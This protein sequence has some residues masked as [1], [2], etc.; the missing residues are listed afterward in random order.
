MRQRRATLIA[1]LVLCSAFFTGAWSAAAPTATT[2]HGPA[3]SGTW[4]TARVVPGTKALNQ[5]GRATIASISCVSPGNCSAG[6]TYA[7]AMGTLKPVTQALVVTETGGR[8]GTA[9]E[10]PGTAALNT[11]GTARVVSISC[12]AAGDCAA[13][14]FYTDASGNAQ[15]FVVTETG[16]T[17]G[18]A[19]EV[20]G[21][22]GLDRG[23]PGAEVNSVSCAAVG[24]CAAGGFYTETSGH[25]QAFVVT[26]SSGHWGTAREVPGSATLNAG[27]FAGITSLS[28]DTVGNCSAGGYYAT[29]TVDFIPTLEAMVVTETGGTWRAAREVPGTAALN[30][31]GYAQIT[32]LS[33]K[34]AGDCSAGGQYTNGTSAAEAFVV[35]QNGGTWG[36]A[37]EVPG[38]EAL[39]SA[40]FATLNSVS[41]ASPGNC[42]A[43]GSYADANFD[44]QAFVVNQTG[45][46]WGTAQEIPGTAALDVGSPG[47]TAG[48]V[49]CAAVGDCSLGGSYSDA[50]GHQQAFVASETGGTWGTAQEVP[51]TPALNTGGGASID[52]ISCPSAGNCGAGGHYTD[53]TTAQQAFVVSETGGP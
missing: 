41:C 30:A 49:S 37:R 33:C 40:G 39:N 4:G 34:A 48:P 6:G 17:W 9:R 46:T 51:G 35:S 36:T 24:D 12:S 3:L 52:A 47:A 5:G 23:S 16:G 27:G 44:T 14:G 50:S 42:S 38:I 8:W 29:K 15:A 19:Q 32:S 45:G 11:G 7:S 1:A 28:C 10:V 18:T 21:T 26:E 31:G 20:P 2:G 53:S 43:T 13:G 25:E 22:A